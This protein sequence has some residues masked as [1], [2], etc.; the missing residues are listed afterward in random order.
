MPG[1]SLYHELHKHH[2][3]DATA[4]TICAFDIARG[5]QFLHNK[6]IIHRDLKSLNVLLDANGRAKICD[7]G[8]SRDMGEE[9]LY[10]S[11][12]GT[13]HWMAPELLASSSSYNSK[14][15]VYAYGIVLWEI[16][17]GQLPYQGLEST[18]IIAQVMMNDLRPTIPDSMNGLLRDLIT[19]CWDRNPDRRPSFDEIIRRFQSGPIVLNGADREAFQQYMTEQ[20][21]NG[22]SK[23]VE[24]ENKLNTVQEDEAQL[25]DLIETLE[26]DG[27][28]NDLVQRCWGTVEKYLSASPETVGRAAALFLPTTY[29]AKAAAVL[30][31]LPPG[32]VPTK[33]LATAVELI[34]SGSVEFDADICVAACKN[35]AADVC[36]VYA[37]NPP[38]LKLALEIVAQQGAA[39]TLR[40]AVADRCVQCLSSP[41]SSMVCAAM[42][43][44]IGINDAKRITLSTLKTQ[45]QSRDKA[46][47]NCTLVA[48]AAM[49]LSGVQ[50]PVEVVDAVIEMLDKEPFAVTVLVAAC[51]SA[52][53][54][55][56]VV[57]RIAYGNPI[58]EETAMRIL[59]ISAQHE[60]LRPAVMVALNRLDF[61]KASPSVKDA[62][63]SLQHFVAQR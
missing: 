21:G 44:L 39:P 37:M 23:E 4:R 46:L 13:P 5:V 49:S 3:L 18:Q 29:K 17:T 38:Y 15:D 47:K 53:V 59:L 63:V 6:H 62:L 55:I 35:G 20:I 16:A 1:D 11:N 2:K 45:L 8:F 32:S 14:I 58:K 34:P 24:L 30:R 9:D 33:P 28:P 41:D 51:K 19:A 42:R 43:C 12:V 56:Q 54:A 52:Q 48:A 7:F 36:V 40:A 61:S 57:N 26:H 31:K 10:T 50:M 60:E 25:R 27:I 22:P